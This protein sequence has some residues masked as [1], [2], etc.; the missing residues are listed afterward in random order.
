MSAFLFLALAQ[1]APD[2][3]I[4]ARTRRT[5]GVFELSVSGRVR[6]APPEGS[7]GLR[8]HRVAHRA[9]WDQ[10]TIETAVLEDGTGRVAP[11]SRGAFSH[12]ERFEAPGEVELRVAVEGSTEPIRRTLRVGSAADL[13][14]WTRAALQRLESALAEL[15]AVADEAMA[16][17]SEAG[18]DSRA[19]RDLRRRAERR[20]AKVRGAAEKTGLSAAGGALAAL[21]SD[22]EGALTARLDGR[23]ACRWMSSLSNRTFRLE[24][25]A[26]YAERLRSLALREARLMR[27]R[28]VAGLLEEATAAIAAGG[29]RHFD[30]VQASVRKNLE[31]IRDLGDEV[32]AGPAD[33][34]E[35][36]LEL[37]SAALVCEMGGGEDWGGHAEAAAERLQAIETELRNP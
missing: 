11:L 36:L 13:L 27:I 37:G 28:E 14:A 17:C 10:G 30:R 15:E 20:L 35:R 24:E 9:D 31:A 22:V 6:G 16:A 7:V 21:A 2:A 12:A 4:E 33:D 29:A 5:E 19:A 1:Q 8:F 34:L 3:V 18:L 25:M 32:L 26:E 23:P